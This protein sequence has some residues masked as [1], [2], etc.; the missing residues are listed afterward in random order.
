MQISSDY[1]GNTSLGL[2]TF[3]TG[4]TTKET[5]R[6]MA[7][8]TVRTTLPRSIAGWPR[9]SVVLEFYSDVT[10]LTEWSVDSVQ[11]CAVMFSSDFVITYRITDPKIMF[12][13]AV[14]IVV[15]PIIIMI[16]IIVVNITNPIPN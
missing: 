11:S 3:N 7:P 5:S 13:I 10:N 4:N 16:L 6:R 9:I 12:M 14:I 1:K 8:R 15:I 2:P